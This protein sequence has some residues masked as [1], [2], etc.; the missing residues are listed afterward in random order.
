[1]IEW[2]QTNNIVEHLFKVNDHPEIIRQGIYIPQFM[3][4]RNLL[5]PKHLDML[6]DAALVRLQSI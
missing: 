2:L 4:Q 6:W 1:M 5:E 3:A